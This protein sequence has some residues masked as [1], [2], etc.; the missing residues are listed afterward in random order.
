MADAIAAER[1]VVAA[2]AMQVIRELLRPDVSPTIRLR[3]AQAAL[4]AVGGI[5]DPG[6]GE[7]D[8]DSLKKKW[9]H[10]AMLRRLQEGL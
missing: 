8:S 7:T 6:V 5:Q 9:D 1:C 4:E 2:E 3:A 10:A